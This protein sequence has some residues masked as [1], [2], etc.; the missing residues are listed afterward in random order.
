[1]ALVPADVAFYGASLKLGEQC[2][3]FVQSNAYAKLKDLPAEQYAFERLRAESTKRDTPIGH[4]AAAIHEPANRELL[5]LLRD[6]VRQ[7]FFVYGS[8]RWADLAQI[9]V[10][11]QGTARFGPALAALQGQDPEAAQARAII[12]AL[13]AVGDKLQVPDLV[14][15]FRVTKTET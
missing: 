15:G 14:L 11:L 2:D 3:R 10:E 7:E 8:N 6:A 1:L 12:S 5:D 9:A 4:F 13:N